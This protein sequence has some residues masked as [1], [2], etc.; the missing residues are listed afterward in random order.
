MRTLF[1]GV[2]FLGLW[3]ILAW[4]AVVWAQKPV[5]TTGAGY[6]AMVEALTAAYRATGG[7]IEELYGGHI[8][9]I[10]AQI[11]QGS[12]ANLVISDQA[13][14]EAVAGDVK[15]EKFDPLGDT[16]LVLAW[17][18][19]LSLKSPEDLL[20]P[21]F[22]KVAHP[23]AQAAIYGRAAAAFLKSSGLGQKLGERLMAV[24]SVPQVLAYLIAGEIDA[25][26]VNRAVIQASGDKI[27]GSLEITS[28]YPPIHLVVATVKGHGQE[29]GVVKFLEFLQ[30]PKA[31]E[32]L[33]QYGVWR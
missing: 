22:Q 21:Q 3:I 28:G 26:F 4:P 9:Q 5:V 32:I 8:G 30:S 33:R 14:L 25:G 10:V 24:S 12:G 11:A 18:Q 15:F 23:D 31:Q 1:R 19:G 13:T 16:V 2:I 17:R 6:K 29:P 7:E 27:G 20:G